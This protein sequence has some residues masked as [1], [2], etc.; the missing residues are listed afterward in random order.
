MVMH[1]GEAAV[2][3]VFAEGEALVVEAK[4]VE[5]EEGAVATSRARTEAAKAAAG[6][7]SPPA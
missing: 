1:V 5:A 6:S 2:D 4:L 3:A 7:G